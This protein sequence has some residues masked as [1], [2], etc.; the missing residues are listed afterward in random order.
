VANEFT[1]LLGDALSYLQDPRRTQQLQGVGNALSQSLMGLK[2]SDV[3]FQNAYKKAFSDPK[4]PMN[5]TDRNALSE[6]TDMTMAGPM[7]FAPAGVISSK[8]LGFNSKKLAKNYPDTSPGELKID[9]NTG[10]EYIGKVNSAEADAV[11]KIRK[12]AQKDIDAGNYTP[13][14]DVSKRFYA[15]PNNYPIQGKTLTDIIPAKQETIDKYQQIYNTP[16]AKSRL[17]QAYDSAVKDPLAHDFYAMGQLEK[18]FINDFGEDLGRKL[19]KERFADAMSATTGGADP[20]SNFLMAQ[21][22]NFLKQANKPQPTNAYD[23]PFPIGGRF[24]SGN[25]A[26][27]DKM[28][29]QGQGLTVQNP[30]RFNFS[31]D[32][33]GYRDRPTLDEQMSQLFVPGLLAPYPNTYGIAESVLNDVAKL[34]NVQPVNFQDV[35]WA[36]KKQVGG[37]PMIQT[38]NEAIERTSR[39]TNLPQDEVAKLMRAGKIPTYG[40]TG[41]GLLGANDEFQQL[42]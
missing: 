14:Y 23:F 16:E 7:G 28:M 4:N 25:M 18:D 9:K 26:L 3:N 5:V 40:I 19:F 20:T 22:G 6:L 37:K 13:F 31:S 12:S 41:V 21:Y 38:V 1:G 24:A 42:D 15:D 30:K 11:A 8:T 36:G 35:A 33:L 29:N 27:Y 32:F 34:R 2:Q 10:K 17:L 39:V